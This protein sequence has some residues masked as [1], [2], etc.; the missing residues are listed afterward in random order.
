MFLG[1]PDKWLV[2]ERFT[3]ADIDLTILLE[4]LNVIGMDER[5]WGNSKRPCIAKF[6]NRVRQRPSYKAATPSAFFHVKTMLQGIT[7]LAF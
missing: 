4:R 5:A 3:L 7:F 2:S 6:W 1:E